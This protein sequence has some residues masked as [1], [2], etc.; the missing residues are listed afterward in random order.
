M[1]YIE[2]SKRIYL[3]PVIEELHRT[4]VEMEMDDES[5]N[6]E[7]NLNYAI[8]RLLMMV[9]GNSDST[10]YRDINDA[11]GVLESVK[12]EFYHKVARPYEDQKCF[13]NGDIERF[14]GK[15]EVIGFVDIEVIDPE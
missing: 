8:T 14:T 13:E 9:Y 7:G 2:N 15:P 5:T 6:T 3:D 12:L 10:S 11:I 4:L 1:P